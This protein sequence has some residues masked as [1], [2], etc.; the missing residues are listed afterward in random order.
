MGR[1]GTIYDPSENFTT[2]Q[3]CNFCFLPDETAVPLL[4]TAE[5]H[6]FSDDYH[7]VE[8]VA[9]SPARPSYLMISGFISPPCQEEE[10]QE[11]L[12]TV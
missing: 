2:T 6:G 10:T 1:T 8:D 9:H 4:K 7:E 12:E 5:C 3:L 11:A